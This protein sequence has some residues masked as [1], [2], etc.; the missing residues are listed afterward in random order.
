MNKTDVLIIGGSA[1]GLAT[2]NSGKSNYPDKDFLLLRKEKEV[3]VPC[4]IPYIFGSL[5]SS[6]Q[7]VMPADAMYDKLGIRYQ[8]GIVKTIKR[9]EKIV[10]LEDGEEIQYDKLVLATGSTPKVPSWLKGTDL[11]NVFTIPKN[12][13]YLDQMKGQLQDAKKVVTIGAG[14]I[15]VEMSDEFVKD[16][17]EVSLVEK[18]PTILGV[19]FDEEIAI[20]AQDKLKNHGVTVYTG[21]GVSEI[22]GKNG[23]VSAVKLEDGTTID[24]DAVVLAMGYEANSEL[25]GQ[26]GIKLA[27]NN[28]IS[29][30]E[31]M[32]TNDPSIIAVGDCAEKRH[33]VTRKLSNIM[34][35]STA[36]A[37]GRI[38]GMNLF[39][40]SAVKTFSGTIA[41]YSTAI[42]DTALG[43]A[44]VT[45]EEAKEEGFD[46]VTG[47]FEGIDRH[48]GK[49]PNMHKQAVKLIVA[50]DSGVIIG[51]EAIGGTSVGELTNLLG[52]IIQSR[53]TI[54]TLITAQIGTHP[55]LTGSP[56]AYPLMK[57]A[58]IAY[59][60]LKN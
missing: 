47:Y 45:E 50:R 48:P 28:S 58:E 56:A 44:G 17:K 26:S 40:L 42:G 9:E 12:K 36:C 10:T 29:V 53:T 13:V 39:K 46:I 24:A 49:L 55:M 14:F 60:K 33:F 43:T 37:E 19:A 59:L 3:M 22:Q 38:A 11:E 52:F 2:A 32:R 54:Q 16:G 25:A 20:P 15:G 23:K 8:T 41:I 7:N 5:E 31:Y 57:A 51:G 4:G 1:A 34:L 27:D 35:A 30:D 18:L 21:T 6:N